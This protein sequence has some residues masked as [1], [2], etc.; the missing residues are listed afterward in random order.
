MSFGTSPA[1][2]R[3]GDQEEEAIS[4]AVNRA[5][6]NARGRTELLHADPPRVNPD[7]HK[8]EPMA[9]HLILDDRRVVVHEDVLDRNGGD[10]ADEDAPESVGNRGV[11]ADEVERDGRGRE[12]V[13]C[14]LSRLAGRKKGV[15]GK[16]ERQDGEREARRGRRRSG[17]HSGLDEGCSSG[18]PA[19]RPATLC[20]SLPVQSA[21]PTRPCEPSTF[22]TRTTLA[23]IRQSTAGER[24]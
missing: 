21:S 23:Q 12:R 17:Q 8:P 2:R 16:R 7:G 4:R 20:R 1:R 6:R 15:G 11:E 18:P 5:G 10:L 22:L 14:D 24:F 13:D 9:Q 19:L 3:T